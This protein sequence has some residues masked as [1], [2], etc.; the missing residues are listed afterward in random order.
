MA[1]LNLNE[2]S[3]EFLMGQIQEILKE[4]KIQQIVVRPEMIDISSL[5][6]DKQYVPSGVIRLEVTFYK[7]R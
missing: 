6:T 3:E 5:E 1:I 4:H 7:I 2:P